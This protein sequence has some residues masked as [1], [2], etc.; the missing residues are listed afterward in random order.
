MPKR[1]GVD[2]YTEGSRDRHTQLPSRWQPALTEAR[3]RVQQ[4]SMTTL[5]I[6]G[7]VS[8]RSRRVAVNQN[9]PEMVRK[10]L[11][12]SVRRA[13][14]RVYIFLILLS[15]VF[16]IFFYLLFFRFRTWR[17]RAVLLRRRRCQA[18]AG[19]PGGRL[20]ACD[21]RD[22]F[23]AGAGRVVAASDADSPGRLPQ[24][25]RFLARYHLVPRPVVLPPPPSPNGLA[26]L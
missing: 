19:T 8:C 17:T 22:L 9:A 14:P 1:R 6:R 25:P 5:N 4:R 24:Q 21:F 26:G 10:L 12:T 11:K 20:G 23:G 15:S 16:C 3:V 18:G 7:E 13:S 2:P